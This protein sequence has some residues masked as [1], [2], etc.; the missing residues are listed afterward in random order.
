MSIGIPTPQGKHRNNRHPIL[1]EDIAK[2]RKAGYHG[3]PQIQE[4]LIWGQTGSGSLGPKREKGVHF[5]NEV[6]KPKRSLLYYYT[7][8]M[9]L[10]VLFN[11]F[12]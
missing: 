8:M 6:K 3:F 1:F 2:I 12:I 9:L 11:S 7:V 5:V 10:F 4:S